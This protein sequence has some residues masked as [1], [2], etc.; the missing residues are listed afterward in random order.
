[1]VTHDCNL[2]R[3]YSL[4]FRVQGANGI[5]EVDGN[6][7]YIEGESPEHRWEDASSW[8]SR[9]DHPLWKKY[10]EIATGSGHGGMDFFVLN[11]FVESARRKIAPP[12]DVYDAAAWSALTP[13]SEQ[14]IAQGGAPQD[15]PD[16]TKGL[17]ESRPPWNW[18]SDA[19]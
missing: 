4:G 18:S 19:Y 17:W 14:S 5:W 9:Y 3:P 6:R 10:G 7:I 12:L 2:P 16:F 8:L 15:F 1:I 13:L 11:A